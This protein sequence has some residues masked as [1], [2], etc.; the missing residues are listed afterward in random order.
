MRRAALTLT[1]V[2]SAV[3]LLAACTEKPQTNAE[4]VKYDAVPW[5]GT[6]TQPD[7]GTAFT[8]AGWKP[9]DRTSWEQHLKTRLQNGQNEYNRN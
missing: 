9:G 4:G 7:S 8:D 6:G 2:A 5:S 1:A 3:V